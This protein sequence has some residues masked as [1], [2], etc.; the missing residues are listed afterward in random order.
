ML[1][2]NE[3]IN[4]QALA[5]IPLKG[6][7]YTWSNMQDAPL[8]EKLN[9]CFTSESWALSFPS[10]MA[11]PLAKTTSDHTPVL[12]KIGTTIP[13][14][15]IFRFENFWLKHSQF[16]EV[17][18]QIWEQDIQEVDSA[19]CIAAKFKRLRKGHKIWA[20][21]VSNMKATIENTNF[22][23][24]CYDV[25]EEYRDLSNEEANGRVIL[26]EHLR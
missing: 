11:I 9:W 17:V 6:R 26:I 2:F 7:N 12:I 16:K 1:L 18:K 21:T 10:T 25:I 8:L 24:L 4:R 20:K 19:K 13:K 5:E 23:I 14:S 15:H 22:M 3:A